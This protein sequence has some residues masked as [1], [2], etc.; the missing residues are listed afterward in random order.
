VKRRAGRNRNSK[1]NLTREKNGRPSRAAEPPPERSG[2]EARRLEIMGYDRDHLP[3]RRV[4]AVE[5]DA[6][7]TT[8]LG[9][10][11]VRNLV[12]RTQ[13]EAGEELCRRW[14]TGLRPKRPHSCVHEKVPPGK[15]SDGPS[16]RAEQLYWE[17]YDVLKALGA[18]VY[19]VT[20]NIVLWQHPPRLLDVMRRRT[21]DGWDADQ[22]T[23]DALRQGLD[24]LANAF[25][26]RP[27]LD[28]DMPSGIVPAVTACLTRRTELARMKS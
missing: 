28:E 24:A 3:D 11:Y 21:R 20:V 6:R 15:P 22:R 16:A 7:L 17:A 25:G 8:P 19:H 14:E 2:V 26:L 13:F 5:R 18:K 4:P 12:T 10:M 27:S 9:L 1:A 23:I